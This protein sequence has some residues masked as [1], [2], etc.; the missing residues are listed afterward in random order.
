MLCNYEIED[1][2]HFILNCPKLRNKRYISETLRKKYSEN[3]ENA[4]GEFLFD[5]EN[6][7][8]KKKELYDMWKE[9]KRKIKFIV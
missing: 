9:R 2:Y 7:E 1:I 3:Q 8:K 6:L 4:I 5:E